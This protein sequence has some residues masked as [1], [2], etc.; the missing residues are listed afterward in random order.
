M[1]VRA[2]L[3]GPVRLVVGY[4]TLDGR[5]LGGAL[6]QR[7]L[8]ALA[9]AAGPVSRDQLGDAVWGDALPR[10][11]E[12]ALRGAVHKLRRA[13]S[14]CGAGE[15]V[16]TAFGAYQLDA[17]VAI[18]V[19]GAVG[20]V[21]A[22]ERALDMD[23]PGAARAA[24]GD[25]AAV[26]DQ[27]FM[28]G[29]DGEWIDGVR[30][31]LAP[32]R[33]RAHLAMSAAATALGDHVAAV[34]A[35][36][37]AVAAEPYAEVAHRRLM[38]ALAAAGDRAAAL[39]AYRQCRELLA[40]ELGVEPSPETDAARQAVTQ[41]DARASEPRPAA[42]VLPTQL[43]ASL[44]RPLS[45][46]GRDRQLEELTGRVGGRASCVLVGAAGVGKSRL[47]AELA[48]V[49]H[50]QG[51]AV[52]HAAIEPDDLGGLGSFAELLGQLDVAWPPPE[53][54]G[55]ALVVDRTV[56]A[57][58]A[59]DVLRLAASRRPLL[60]VLD[61]LHWA[62]R[63]TAAIVERVVTAGIDG[64][65]MVATARDE[66]LEVSAAGPGGLLE[67]VDVIGVPPLDRD[68]IAGL[69]AEWAG[70]RPGDT[71]LDAIAS[72]TGGN[73]FYVLA[74]VQDLAGRAGELSRGLDVASDVLEMVPTGVAGLVDSALERLGPEARSF[75]AAA[76]V[77]GDEVRM[78]T[79]QAVVDASATGGAVSAQRLLLTRL[80]VRSP[81]DPGRLR[82]AHALVREAVLAGIPWNERVGLHR[83]IV[84]ALET[85]GED[86]P[87]LV[88]RHL[89]AAGPPLDA[90]R[91]AAL[92]T[93]VASELTERGRADEA[94][95]VLAITLD[96]L[97]GTDGRLRAPVLMG[98]AMAELSLDDVVAGREH[99]RA[100][101]TLAVEVGDVSFLDAWWGAL[102][103]RAAGGTDEEMVALVESVV[104]LTAPASRRRA[105]ALGWLTLELSVG[106]HM[107]R[108]LE[109]GDEALA[110]A[111]RIGDEA[112]L[113]QTV[114]SWH[115]AARVDVPA[116]ERRAVMEDVLGFRAPP[117]SRPR[118]CS[119]G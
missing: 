57:S 29:L 90:P 16:Q 55:A 69:V 32:V 45:L 107:D 60:I 52:I 105:T 5:A 31:R 34:D 14:R 83:A 26:L 101:A 86:S 49:R 53:L 51:A 98:L 36:R 17:A 79:V 58:A 68:G 23:D 66:W 91:V 104:A 46:T 84:H 111:R 109:V 42:P 25:A 77:L 15:I 30:A 74:V 117:A 103:S 4:E 82:W 12:T 61:D 21:T 70:H 7:V 43:P 115:L 99:L 95:T 56:L 10:T 33:T 106:S 73:P 116:I 119:G 93:T 13:A 24:A 63:S 72:R 1:R 47:A 114:H 88:L 71:V 18:D 62:D 19:T 39:T 54:G 44:R 85:S 28:A 27:P 11:W 35:A 112:L 22:A 110:L 108:A 97:A 48:W 8:A 87:E 94:T 81:H 75:A 3:A 102:S 118:T 6:A 64:L 50:E 38:T 59:I 65:S 20:W 92:A 113:R 2:E 9:M 78:S 76:A 37:R 41:S 100:A 80:L 96:A 89:L 40:D 67:H